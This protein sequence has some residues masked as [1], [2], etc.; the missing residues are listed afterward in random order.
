VRLVIGTGGR[1]GDCVYPTRVQDLAGI[2]IVGLRAANHHTHHRLDND[3]SADPASRVRRQIGRVILVRTGR[4]GLGTE[5]QG[6]AGRDGDRAPAVVGV[7][8]LRVPDMGAVGNGVGIVDP[9][10]ASVPVAGI[11]HEGDARRTHPWRRQGGSCRVMRVGVPHVDSQ[12]RGGDRRSAESEGGGQAGHPGNQAGT[13]KQP[14]HQ[15]GAPR[16]RLE[17]PRAVPRAATSA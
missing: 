6:A 16:H 10:G 17:L 8:A 3:R 13:A 15:A 2:R 7:G 12:R 11:A 9:D 5:D 4:G 14:E 1:A